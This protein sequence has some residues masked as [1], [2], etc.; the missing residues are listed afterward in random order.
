M[1]MKI[2]AP[3]KLKLVDD[4]ITEFQAW[5]KSADGGNLD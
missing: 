1:K 2:K 3:L 5:L 4:V